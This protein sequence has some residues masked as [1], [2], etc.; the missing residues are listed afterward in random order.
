MIADW[1]TP[2]RSTRDR[3]TVLTFFGG[4][5]AP[6][7]QLASERIKL[8]QT[9]FGDYEQTIREDLSRVMAGTAF[10]FDRDVTSIYL[11]RWGHGMIMPTP[12]QLFGNGADRKG[13][14]RHV[15]AAPLG[16]ISFAGQETEGRPSVE[17]AMASGDR[18]AKEVL[19]H[20]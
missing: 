10:D 20:L 4:N 19:R 16:R 14:P 2:N 5:T 8:L 12:G 7:A 18:A 17:C 11:Y 3:R 1:A 15:A 6:P 9:P 13:S